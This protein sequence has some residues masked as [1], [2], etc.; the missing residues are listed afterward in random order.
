MKKRISD[1]MD[2][3]Q[4]DSVQFQ[5]RNIASSEIIQEATMN[6]L[7]TDMATHRR[8]RR[9][10]RVALIAAAIVMLLAVSG[11]AIYH[12]GLRDLEGTPAQIGGEE[13]P[14]LAMVGFQGSP[15]Y[16]V[17]EE[18]ERHVVQWY[19]AGKNLLP[20]DSNF[21]W[22]AYAE[23]SA[24]SQEARD[25]LDAILTTY[26]LRL[27]ACVGEP[28][29]LEAL[30][31]LAGADGFMPAPGDSGAYPV[32][33][34]YYDDGSFTFNCAAALPGN[35]DLRYQFHTLTK[36][37]FRRADHL[38]A[39]IDAYEEWTYTTPDGVEVLLAIG[40]DKSFLAAD[41]DNSFVF[42]NIL[43][44]TENQE[45]GKTSFGAQTVGQEDLEAF[46]EGFDFSALNTLSA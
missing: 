28:R 33:G 10:A 12:F 29:S 11:I 21:V 46:A 39:D 6:K 5:I 23:Q 1:M 19:E 13:F 26:G 44:G 16:E 42:V 32:G 4:D 36:G 25:T 38:L 8:T 14:T 37:S 35:L 22:D 30:Y 17:A 15:A 45:A 20:A 9:G 3:I 43:S 34:K 31:D 27:P 24:F 7:H 40:T 41:L 2:Y 18:W